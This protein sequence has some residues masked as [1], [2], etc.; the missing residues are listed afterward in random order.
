[1]TSLF[2]W[3]DILLAIV[4]LAS[5]AAG[6]RTGFARVVVG[7]AATV[8]GFLAGFWCYRLVAVKLQPWITT[9]SIASV[10]GFLIIFVGISILGALIA[11]LLSRV[12]QWVGL[13]WFNHLL[14]GAAG[15][16]RGVLIVAVLASVLVAFAPSP[17]PQY[18][19]TS[20]VLPYANN[21]AAVLAEL[22]PQQLKDSFSQQMQNLKQSHAAR[23]RVHEI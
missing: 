6:L 18:L 14:G 12:L 15:L 10:V 16:L 1:M 3:F 17:T 21:V 4:I 9:P 8:A 23:G 19:Q 7:F 22:A 11:A 5:A 13:S 2:N 20:R